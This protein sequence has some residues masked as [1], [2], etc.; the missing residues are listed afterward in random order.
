[1]NLTLGNGPVD[2]PQKY[3]KSE[4]YFFLS[5]KFIMRRTLT[6]YITGN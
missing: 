5:L 3:A 6:Q 4:T 1:M 2:G